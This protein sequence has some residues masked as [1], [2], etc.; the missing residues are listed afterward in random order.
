MVLLAFYLL[1]MI[2]T[3]EWP[4]VLGSYEK[5]ECLSVKEYLIRRGYEL[6]SC[7]LMTLQEDAHYI[8]VPYLP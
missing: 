4:V 8:Q 2:P 1:V 3:Q 7:E 5:E 6:S